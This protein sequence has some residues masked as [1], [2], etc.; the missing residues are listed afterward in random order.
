MRAW[1]LLFQS[2]WSYDLR[3]HEFTWLVLR[4]FTKYDQLVLLQTGDGLRVGR[5]LKSKGHVASFNPVVATHDE[6]GPMVLAG[7]LH[8]LERH[9][10]NVL[11]FVQR[12][13]S[14][15]V[16]SGDEFVFR[17]GHIDF[18]VH[19]ARSRIDLFG[20]PDDSAVEGSVICGDVDG[21]CLAEMK[22]RYSPF[23]HRDHET[24]EGVL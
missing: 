21:N 3:H 20:E 8:R 23:R 4:L 14:G 13:L 18:G 6:H 22:I 16:H 10:Q 11:R 12:D 15:S 1:E 9:G 7:G 19:R 24:Q 17:I 2:R 5:I